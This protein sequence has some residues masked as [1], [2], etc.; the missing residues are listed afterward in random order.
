MERSEADRA[1]VMT[2][3]ESVRSRPDIYFRVGR[4]SPELPTEV[5][6]TVVWDAMH[7]RDGSHGRV[8]VEISSDLGFTVEDDRLRTADDL[9]RPLPGFYGSLLDHARWAPAAAAALS[10]RTVIEVWLEG[11]GYRQELVGSQPVGPW[12]EFAA[13]AAN[14]TRTTFQLDPAYCAPGEAIAWALVPSELHGEACGMH[15]P[16][17]IRDLRAE[18]RGGSSEQNPST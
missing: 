1:G 2:F 6:Q 17:A 18:G 3:G 5:L 13:P 12:E 9:G 15:P 10:S 14:G 16:M 8:A 11:R 4:D 7:R